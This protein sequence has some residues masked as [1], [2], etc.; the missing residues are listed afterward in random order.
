MSSIGFN[1]PSPGT[2]AGL[3]VTLS[4]TG[5]GHNF[6]TGFPE[7]RIA[8]LSIHAFDLASGRELAIYDAFWKRTSIGVGGLT[9]SLMHQPCC[10]G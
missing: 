10:D 8:W 4:N 5:S 1:A 9:K 6:P 2:R 7:G 3:T